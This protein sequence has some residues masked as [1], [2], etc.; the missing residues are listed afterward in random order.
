VNP[1]STVADARVETIAYTVADTQ[2]A[3]DTG[4][5]TVSVGAGTPEP[6][7]TDETIY[8]SGDT[9]LQQMLRSAEGG[10]AI[11]AEDYAGNYHINLNRI[12]GDITLV[13]VVVDT[14]PKGADVNLIFAGS[15][16]HDIIFAG[17]NTDQLVGG[18]GID[19]MAGGGGADLFIF[20]P[21]DGLNIVY[22]FTDGVDQI[23]LLGAEFDDLT[24]SSY[25]DEDTLITLNDDRLILRN[26]DFQD[27]SI[28]DFAF[29]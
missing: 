20:A 22:D 23:G 9:E 3:T 27:L 21:G 28:D 13:R 8:V 1:L 19:R 26:T 5:L 11:Y 15:S 17:D 4:T 14:P 7:V 12:D 25:R 18:G 16:G 24:I 29:L 10:E 6:I 2:G